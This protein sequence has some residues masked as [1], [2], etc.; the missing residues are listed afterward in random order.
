M[1]TVIAIFVTHDCV[2]IISNATEQQFFSG[3]GTYIMNDAIECPGIVNSVT[4]CGFLN[5]E[6][7]SV[8]TNLIAFVLGILHVRK[9]SNSFDII[10]SEAIYLNTSAASTARNVTL[11]SSNKS[12]GFI[13]FSQDLPSWTVFEG[14]QFGVIIGAQCYLGY[15]PLQVGLIN[16]GCE[17]ASLFEPRYYLFGGN[18]Q[19]ITSTS[20]SAVK[21]NLKVYI[22]E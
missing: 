18:S 12:V 8:S 13:C 17:E 11:E 2:D 5:V 10:D 1:I 3:G 19:Q 16:T 22:G 7:L 9:S 20:L 4:L 6:D 14:D 21:I 15:C